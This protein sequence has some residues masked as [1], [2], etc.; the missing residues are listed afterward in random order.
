MFNAGAPTRITCVRAGAYSVAI[1]AEWD[2]NA[3]GYRFVQLRANGATILSR[4]NQQAVTVAGNITA[5]NLVWT[6]WSPS[7]GDYIEVQAGQG[8]GGNLNLWAAISVYRF[9]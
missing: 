1:N 3:V 2:V 9:Q 4:V 5:Q 6:G 7:V 8:S